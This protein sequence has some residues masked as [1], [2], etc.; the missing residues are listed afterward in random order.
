RR[1]SALIWDAR[2]I[3][4]NAHIFNE[5]RSKI[6]Y[7]AKII[8]NVLQRFINHPSCTDIME[9]YNAVEE[10]DDLTQSPPVEEDSEAPG[11]SSGQRGNQLT[12]GTHGCLQSSLEVVPDREA[13]KNQCKNLIN[14]IFECEDSQP[15][16]EP[17]DLQ[18]N[19]DY[20]DII[21]TPMDFG[22]VKRTLWDDRYEN[23]LEL[24]KDVRLIFANARAYTPNKRSQVGVRNPEGGVPL[25]CVSKLIASPPSQ[26][27]SMT[28]RLSALFEE[29]IRTVISDYTTAVKS[30]EQVRRSQRF[31]KKTQQQQQPSAAA[32]SE[33]SARLRPTPPA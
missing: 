18:N 2:Y 4:H 20:H 21:D 8:T 17:V 23:P 11:T 1:I 3:A 10:M 27:Y 28:L 13:W 22:S 32:R 12:H 15:F 24:C 25:G 29:R 7:S 9:I 33:P 16:R 30:S 14:Y 19:P 26:I 5:P 31:R 6:A